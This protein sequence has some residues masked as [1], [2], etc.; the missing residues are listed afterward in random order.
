MPQ[1]AAPEGGQGDFEAP[2]SRGSVSATA[3]AAAAVAAEQGGRRSSSFQWENNEGA[4]FP[5]RAAREI[6]DNGEHDSVWQEALYETWDRL[7][8]D[9]RSQKALI[10]TQSGARPCTFVI[11][12]QP[13]QLALL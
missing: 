13:P 2:G 3:Y 10:P 6:S 11:K 7:A 9:V 12:C 5:G 8:P 4:N 1:P